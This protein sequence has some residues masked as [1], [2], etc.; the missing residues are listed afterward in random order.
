MRSVTIHS[1]AKECGMSTTTV[2]RVL[3]GSDYPVKQVTKQM[4]LEAAEKVGYVPNM[5][6][7]GL[8]TKIIN[9]VAVI[10]PSV[11]YPFYTSLVEGAESSLIDSNYCMS[12]YLTDN[13]ERHLDLFA[14]NLVGKMMTGII[15]AADSLTPQIH[16]ILSKLNKNND[17]NIIAVD[18]QKKDCE[19]PGIY[20]DFNKGTQLAVSYLLNKG[21]SRI[22]FAFSLLDR[23]TRKE[24]MA[25][26]TA[27]LQERNK[28]N[29]S[30]HVFES[31]EKDGFLAGIELANTI[32]SSHENYTAVAAGNDALAAGLLAGLNERN[33]RVPD[34][35]SVIGFDDCIYA[36][37]CRPALTSV[38]VPSRQMGSLAAQM[39]LGK[40]G[41]NDSATNIFMESKV[42]E[43][44]SVKS[45]LP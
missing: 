1:V 21:H 31:S 11:Q 20:F 41:G 19:F 35:I 25:G 23:E 42:I 32:C 36:L 43:R 6:A 29:I 45:L 34:D 24:R 27:G 40:L 28:N 13:Y 18:Y 12:L 8:K 16:N 4:I 3:S 33:I 37:M 38:H 30:K 9:E 22:A 17:L 26:I 7:R 39:L 14:N 44:A 2:S 5:I 15:I 10:V